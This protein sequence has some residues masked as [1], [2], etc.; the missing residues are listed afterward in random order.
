MVGLA[1]IYVVLLTGGFPAKST[2]RRKLIGVRKEYSI[3]GVIALLPHALKYLLAWITGTETFEWWGV[4]SFV[5]MIPLF[6]TSFTIIRRKMTPK[7]WKNL[8]SF[9]YIA[10]FLLFIH[11]I[12][13]YT[14]TVNLIVYVAMIST[15]II[16][17]THYIGV[18]LWVNRRLSEKS[19]AH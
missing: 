19:K 7:A 3:Y 2:I 16:L 5:I 18:A 15:Y 1:F 6:I 17:K 11:L 12:L 10:Y 13:R 4:L 8:Q 14:E 9:A